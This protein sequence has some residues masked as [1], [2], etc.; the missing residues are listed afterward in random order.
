RL[1]HER[2]VE[3]REVVAFRIGLE[4]ERGQLPLLHPV[5]LERLL[6]IRERGHRLG[7]SALLHRRVHA[8][9]DERREDGDDRD[10]DQKLDERERASPRSRYP[11]TWKHARLLSVVFS[12]NAFRSLVR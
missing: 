8:R 7:A 2:G 12:S 9:G 4:A 3:L 11:Y 5:L 10:D 6:E 1:L